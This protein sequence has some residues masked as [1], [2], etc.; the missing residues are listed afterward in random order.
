MTVAVT[1]P[2]TGTAEA[3]PAVRFAFSAAGTGNVSLTVGTPAPA[4]RSELATAVGARP[5]DLVFMQQVHGAGV[6]VVGPG[7]RGRGLSAHGDSVAA[8][9]ALVTSAPDVA[10]TVLVADCVPVLLADPGRAVAAVHAGRGGVVAGVVAGTVRALDPADPAHLEAAI[11]PAIGGCC[12]E[13]ETGLADA[14]ARTVPRAR[15]TTTWGTP[16]LDL[17]AAV[18]AQLRAVGVERIR[19]FGGCTRCSGTRWY[20]HRRVPG[21]GRQAGVVVRHGDRHA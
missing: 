16:S 17:P 15:A 5:D 6:A 4:A 2:L 19:R 1:A 14:V 21:Q 12:Y 10:L 3:D 8:V 11:G 9:D 18:D 13:V 7:D 20:S